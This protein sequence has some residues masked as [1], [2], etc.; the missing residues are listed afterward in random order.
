MKKQ[1]MAL[2]IIAIGALVAP[3]QASAIYSFM[4]SDTLEKVISAAIIEGGMNTEI[5]YRAGG[6]GKGEGAMARGEQGIAP[7]SRALNEMDATVAAAIRNGVTFIGHV[8]G[9]DGVGVFIN[10]ENKV[11]KLDIPT[12]RRIYTC[13]ITKW[14]QVSGSNLTGEIVP[15]SR[16]GNSGTTDTFKSLVGIK[17]FGKCVKSKPDT[18]AIA[19]ITTQDVK[20]IGYGGKSA[21]RPNNYAVSIARNPGEQAIELNGNT[22]RNE[23]Y[24]LA[25]KL[26]VYEVAGARSPSELETRLLSVLTDEDTMRDILRDNGGFYPV[27]E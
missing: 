5:E 1:I 6:S 20:A 12:I 2:S 22:I 27:H 17:D 14:E 25:R 13:E 16:D 10:K 15:L 19:T 8:I 4:G 18:D 9:L 23:T 3:R 26:Y 21:E 11:I 24:P 7:M